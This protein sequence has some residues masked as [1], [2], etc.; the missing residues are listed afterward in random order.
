VFINHHLLPLQRLPKKNT[1][2]IKHHEKFTKASICVTE[3]A[4]VANE[5]SYV[6]F[7]PI[8]LNQWKSS[9]NIGSWEFDN[10]G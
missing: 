5:A 9:V 2:P 6:H 10:P 8:K 3:L 7:Y 4:S 1:E